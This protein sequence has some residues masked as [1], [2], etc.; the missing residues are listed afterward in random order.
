[1][2]TRE[3]SIISHLHSNTIGGFR[4]L[5]FWLT[6]SSSDVLTSVIH[7]S[8]CSLWQNHLWSFKFPKSVFQW[9]FSDKYF[10]K[11]IFGQVFLDEYFRMSIFRNGILLP[12]LFWP[13]VRKN[14]SSDRECFL[15]SLEQFVWTVVKVR[16]IFGNRMLF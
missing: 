10:Q 6:E 13:T 15:R 8:C 11:S 12:K 9:V 4:K 1:M 7:V 14:C 5:T 2:A 3:M 16:T